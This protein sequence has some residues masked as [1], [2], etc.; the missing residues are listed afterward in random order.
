MSRW[1]IQIDRKSFVFDIIDV[2]SIAL[3]R[4]T[5]EKCVGT[6]FNDKIFKLFLH[7][8]EDCQEF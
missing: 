4:L 8:D 1:N 3:K 2:E 7:S 6:N 5:I